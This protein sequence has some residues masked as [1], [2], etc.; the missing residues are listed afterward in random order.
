MTDGTERLAHAVSSLA[1]AVRVLAGVVKPPAGSAE[2]VNLI[3]PANVIAGATADPVLL[4]ATAVEASIVA[5]DVSSES[6][7]IP[8]PNVDAPAYGKDVT[9]N[10]KDDTI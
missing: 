6:E 7:I 2:D 9:S 8:R 1:D 10:D 3:V 5:S 4:P